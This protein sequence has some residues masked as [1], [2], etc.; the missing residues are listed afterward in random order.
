[1][2]DAARRVVAELVFSDSFWMMEPFM[3]A[4]ELRRAD[5][6]GVGQMRTNVRRY[7]IFH[8]ALQAY[9]LPL[10]AVREILPLAQLSQPPGMPSLL[11]GFLNLEGIAV[12]VVRLSRLF[13]LPE[14]TPGLYAPLL[15]VR[16]ADLTVALLVDSISEIASID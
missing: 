10:D 15:I 13:E 5:R 9:G 3:S 2:L 11:A 6:H 4:A 12:P 7:V 16:A 1:M 8:V 14:Q